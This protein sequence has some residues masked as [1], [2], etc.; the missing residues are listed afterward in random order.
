MSYRVF[1]A[2]VVT[3]SQVFHSS[4]L[5]CAFMMYILINKISRNIVLD[6]K[7]HLQ[8]STL[9]N[10]G[11]IPPWTTFLDSYDQTPPLHS[12]TQTPMTASTSSSDYQMSLDWAS[13]PTYI[14]IYTIRPITPTYI[15]NVIFG[16]LQLNPPLL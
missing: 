16:N 5:F 2:M 11:C 8:T 10:R 12:L 13:S 6:G 7:P 9:L 1:N 4:L 15:Y 14:Q 3:F